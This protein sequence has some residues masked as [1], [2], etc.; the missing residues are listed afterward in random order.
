MLK[1]EPGKAKGMEVPSRGAEHTWP[2]E[3]R[4]SVGRDSCPHIAEGREEAPPKLQSLCLNHS[5]PSSVLEQRLARPP[6]VLEGMRSAGG[7]LRDAFLKYSRRS[8][9]R[10]TRKADAMAARGLNVGVGRRG[11]AAGPAG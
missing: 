11:F 9:L 2:E 4:V 6:G 7:S 3:E 5:D 10:R 8:G 1:T